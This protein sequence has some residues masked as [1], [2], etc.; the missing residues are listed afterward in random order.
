MKLFLRA[1]KYLKPYWLYVLG[2]LIC[3]LMIALANVLIMPVVAELSKA[4]GV[5]NFVRLNFIALLG[6]AL[7][8]MRSVFSYGQIYLMSFSGQRV[9]TDMRIQ[10]YKHLQNLSLDFFTKW[11]TGELMSRLTSDIATLQNAALI[12]FT[13]IL[14]QS[15]TLIGVLGYL[16][17]LNWRLTLLLI[18]TTPIFA[19][20]IFKFGERMREVGR[21][22]Q[23]KAAEIASIIQ[24]TLTGVRV[25]KSF[26]ME[27]HEAE[28]FE[29]E[30]ESSFWFFMRESQI[31]A[32]QKPLLGFLQVL[33][34]IVIIWFAGWEVISGRLEPANLIAFFTGAAL[35][36]DPVIVLGKVNLTV[37]RSLA[38]AERVF[39]VIDI[40]PTVKEVL[41]PIELPVIK[42]KIEF[43]N[44]SFAYGEEEILQNVNLKVEPGEIMA[45]VG[46]SGAGKT[47]LIN[48]IPRFYDATSGEV[49]ADGY[50]VKELGLYDLRRQIGIVPQETMLFS[51]TIK[52]NIAYGKIEATDEEI[53]QAAKI[54][55]AHNFIMGLPKGYETPVG[56]RGTTLSGGQA[57]R[58]AI[59]RAV[60]R[61]PRI[62]IFDEA[63]SYL[64]TESERLVQEAMEKLM[65]GRTTFIIAHRLSTV[66]RAD[67]IVVL[68]QGRIENIGTHE[69]LLNKDGT[70]KKLYEMQFEDRPL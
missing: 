67:R 24:E 40:Q 63:T 54:A 62:L 56:E 38:A 52:D 16:F 10:V 59:A 37:Q 41:Q 49:L 27:K 42:G 22:I 34:V 33:A 18:V 30:S 15:L 39:E 23:K 29:K 4:I 66:R 65:A 19:F 7:F 43:K 55:N 36:I 21:D 13:E 5:K 61:N 35:M 68:N 3:V 11:K 51:G 57:Q 31:D 14:P 60:L 50:N 28:R 47:S 44:V 58:I 8:F 64:D 32:L 9:S 53:I 6:I 2:A 46:P 25:V 12:S 48:L 20:A 17:Y 70:Y 1:L 26:T 69:E 45:L